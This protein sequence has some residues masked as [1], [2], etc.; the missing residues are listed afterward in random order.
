M[1]KKLF[2]ISAISLSMLLSPCDKIIDL[3]VST[4]SEAKTYVYYVSTSYAY[5]SNRNCWTLKRSKKAI[6]KVTLKKA[7]NKK[8]K[9]CGVC[10]K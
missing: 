5:H 3:N 9:P 1:F 10:Y 2:T 7:K 4:V 6:K 8:L